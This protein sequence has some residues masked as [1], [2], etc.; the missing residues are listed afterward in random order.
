[1]KKK[2]KN[3]AYYDKRDGYCNLLNVFG[4]KF[5]SKFEELK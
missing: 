3:C 2:C 5:C 4:M 1:M